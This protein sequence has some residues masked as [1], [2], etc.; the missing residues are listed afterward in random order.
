M[1]IYQKQVNHMLISC[2]PNVLQYGDPQGDPYL[3]TGHGH[4]RPAFFSGHTDSGSRT[5][6]GASTTKEYPCS[7][8]QHGTRLDLLPLF[9]NRNILILNV[10]EICTTLSCYQANAVPRVSSAR[11]RL[12]SLCAVL[13]RLLCH[14]AAI[15]HVERCSSDVCCWLQFHAF[16]SNIV[17]PLPFI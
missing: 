4:G 3:G 5:S 8:Q 1:P 17:L 10:T 15:R 6:Q 14:P 16:G 12:S 11:T 2:R 9:L 7:W 13:F